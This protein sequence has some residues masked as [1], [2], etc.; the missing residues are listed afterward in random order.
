MQ[1]MHIL[2]VWVVLCGLLGASKVH[3]ELTTATLIVMSYDQSLIVVVNSTLAALT[4]PL[5]AV[6]HALAWRSGPNHPDAARPDRLLS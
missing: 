2:L 1:S 6:V 3:R 4:A 5:L